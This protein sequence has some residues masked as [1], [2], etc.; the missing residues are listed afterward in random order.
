M[1]LEILY[2]KKYNI[3]S[4]NLASIDFIMYIRCCCDID[5]VEA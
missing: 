4:K 1:P 5:S 2:A 3:Y